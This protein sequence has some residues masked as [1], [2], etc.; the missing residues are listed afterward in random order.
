[1]N[2]VVTVTFLTI[3]QLLTC[4]AQAYILPFETILSKTVEQSGTSI[5]EID[6]NV[7]FKEGGQE[8]SV[9]EKWLIEGDKNLKLVA[10][11]NGPLKGLI[12]LNYLYNSKKRTHLSGK[13]KIVQEVKPDFFERWLTIRSADSFKNYL[14]EN[15]I[16][17]KVRLSRASG[18]V[19]FAIGE[20]AT[21]EAIYPQVWINQELFHI[22]RLRTASFA[23]LEFANF[24]N[25]SKEETFFQYPLQKNISWSGNN[26]EI[27]VTRVVMKSDSTLKDFYPD[28]IQIP[29]EFSLTTVGPVGQ[30]IEEFYSRFR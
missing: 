16:S 11:G 5:L 23:D 4:S 28:T 26:V 18:V 3:V 29:S 7:I 2:T 8:Y 27:K 9:H 25:Y 30:K 17:N 10:T 14:K 20:M 6:Q 24:N 19:S 1:M 22:N 13:N 21:A 15:S 12:S